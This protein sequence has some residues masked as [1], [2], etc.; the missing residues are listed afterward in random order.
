MEPGHET[1]MIIKRDTFACDFVS[2]VDSPK[3]KQSQLTNAKQ[4]SN[5]VPESQA[6]SYLR[7]GM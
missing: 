3:G 2:E 6:P 1:R 7:Q 4:P 5:F